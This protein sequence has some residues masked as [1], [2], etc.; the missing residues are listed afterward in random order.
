[1]LEIPRAGRR[2]PLRSVVSLAALALSLVPS[3]SDAAPDAVELERER[4]DEG[5]WLYRPASGALPRVNSMVVEQ[6]RGL[7]VV[8]AQSDPERA[9]ALLARLAR[10]FEAPVR[11]LVISHPHAEALGGAS[12]FPETTVVLASAGAHELLLDPDAD[13]GGE[14]R[15]ERGA[16]WTAPPVRMPDLVIHSRL[17]LADAERPVSLLP[18]R[19]AHTAG[20]LLVHLADADLTYAG[21]LLFADRNPYAADASISGWLGALNQLS[22]EAPRTVVGIRGPAL[23]VAGVRRMR[24]AFAWLRGQVENGFIEQHPLERIV[25]EVLANEGL[26]ERFDLAATPSHVALLVDRVLAESVEHRRKRGVPLPDE[27][28]ADG[29]GP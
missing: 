12:A 13:T 15:V 20:D 6:A 1:M 4:L 7:V 27:S 2:R 19:H 23:D 8:D 28:G 10:D 14:L 22:R 3:M 21:G 26:G 29:A 16:G 17:D 18:V 5:V 25:E 9:A 24:D 11:Y